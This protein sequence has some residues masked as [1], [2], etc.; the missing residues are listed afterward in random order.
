MQR[1]PAEALDLTLTRLI[2]GSPRLIP[3]A[4]RSTGARHAALAILDRERVEIERFLTAGI[5]D[6]PSQGP[7]MATAWHRS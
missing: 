4:Q 7:G 2:Q 6:S 5:V 1:T 3:A